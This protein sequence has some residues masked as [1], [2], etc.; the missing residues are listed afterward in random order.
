MTGINL[1]RDLSC[2]SCSLLWSQFF[3]ALVSEYGLYQ[4][5]P[6]SAHIFSSWATSTGPAAETVLQKL[7]LI[8]IDLIYNEEKQCDLLNGDWEQHVWFLVCSCKVLICSDLLGWTSVSCWIF[9]NARALWMGH[10]LQIRGPDRSRISHIAPVKQK[11]CYSQKI[12]Y[13]TWL[14]TVLR[15]VIQQQPTSFWVIVCVK[16]LK[17]KKIELI[18]LH[19]PCMPLAF[20]HVWTHCLHELSLWM[21]A[22]ERSAHTC[23]DWRTA[24]GYTLNIHTFL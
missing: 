19:L 22:K 15:K 4:I 20:P 16:Y 11:R 3:R 2:A 6:Y 23:I 5:S 7:T 12:I 13:Y 18:S 21:Q 10:H 24:G 14:I 1:H 9:R 8:S 17:L